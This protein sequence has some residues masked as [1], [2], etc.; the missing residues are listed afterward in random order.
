MNDNITKLLFSLLRLGLG[1]EGEI[2]ARIDT[3]L[4]SQVYTLACEQGV[5]AV[6][7]DGLQRWLNINDLLPRDLKLRW[8]LSVE[9]I[10]KKYA[11]QYKIASEL[12][13]KYAQEGIRTV[14]LKG[15]A[16]A[17]CYPRPHHRPCGDLDCFLLRADDGRPCFAVGN[18]LARKWKADVNDNPTDYKHSHID[19]KGLTI[20]N[21][22]FLTDIRGRR[23]TKELERELR[24]L[25]REQETTR[26][27]DTHLE[28][29][30]ALFNALFLIKHAQM[31]ILLEGIA[32]RHLCDWAMLLQK[33]GEGIDWSRFKQIC[34][35]YGLLGFAESMTSLSVKYLG[36]RPPYEV[37]ADVARDEFLMREIIYGQQH[38]YTSGYNKW[39]KRFKLVRNI[40]SNSRRYKH[41]SD[42]SS[43]LDAMHRVLGFIF[44]RRPK[45]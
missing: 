24:D 17:K 16:A 12:S 5:Q 30:S 6:V 14:V 34:A 4:L 7:W 20:E 27:N 43:F 40:R 11:R 39:E 42:T 1:Q 8:A 32:L 25:L 33:Q 38:L 29:P 18:A 15:I 45:I 9:G 44:E 26:I 19:Y 36:I 10:E 2:D 3:T 28:S 31:H 21:H 23:K 41:F 35:G 37:E 22:Q 13:R